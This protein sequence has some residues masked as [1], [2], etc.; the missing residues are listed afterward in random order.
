MF[1]SKKKKLLQKA[2][3]EALVA[4]MAKT[5]DTPVTSNTEHPI[6]STDKNTTTTNSVMTTMPC[7]KKEEEQQQQ[8]LKYSLLLDDFPQHDFRSSVILPQLNNRLTYQ[9]YD[10]YTSPPLSPPPSTKSSD[11]QKS[12]S[13]DSSYESVDGTKH[14]RD[15]MAWRH[16]RNQ[17]RYS[18]SLFG[19]KQRNRPKPRPL[20]TTTISVKRTTSVSSK[21]RRKRSTHMDEDQSSNP[22][23]ME[24][25]AE[26][27]KEITQLFLQKQEHQ[28]AQKQNGYIKD[29]GVEE[30]EN[31][32]AL[33]DTSIITPPASTTTE[34]RDNLAKASDFDDSEKESFSDDLDSEHNPDVEDYELD[35]DI[36]ENY[37]FKDFSANEK[38]AKRQSKVAA[39]TQKRA[40]KTIS[41]FDLS[42]FAKDL[43]SNR[44]SVVQQQQ[45]RES[46]VSINNA[47]K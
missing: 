41:R 36:E 42:S 9:H 27:Q 38:Q 14:Y 22:F 25:E 34:V 31:A 26:K 44:L 8:Q 45:M 3:A 2:K 17:N 39:V 16:Q 5:T 33:S 24:Q 28:K 6:Y 46:R 23:D 32:L 30:E 37:F 4:A 1:K 18:N 11:Y 40:T 13:S 15:L 12:R 7:K 47:K 35:S 10:N 21:Q 20:R 43:H 19:G 29:E